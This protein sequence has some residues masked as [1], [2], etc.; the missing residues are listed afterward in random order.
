VIE[1]TTGPST[2]SKRKKAI[3][4]DKEGEQDIFAIPE[5]P[6]KKS[7]QQ[8]TSNNQRT[9]LPILLLTSLAAARAQLLLQLPKTAASAV[10]AVFPA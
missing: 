2:R 6:T 5:S 9:L 10:F 7:K 8:P 1:D 3:S 4:E